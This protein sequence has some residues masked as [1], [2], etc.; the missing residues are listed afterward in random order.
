MKQEDYLNVPS[1]EAG[2]LQKRRGWDIQDVRFFSESEVKKLLYA[3]EELSFLLGRNYPASSVIKLIG[4]RYQL[5]QRQRI[6]LVRSTC[7]P[8]SLVLRQAKCLPISS[9]A[10]GA[11]YIDGFNLII[12][13]EVALSKGIILK[14]QDGCIRDL[15]GLR[16]NYRLIP[17]TDEAIKVL[18]EILETLKAK[19]VHFYLDAPLSNSG[20]L[21][22]KLLENSKD[23]SS[24]VKAEVV[25]NPDQLLSQKE[26]IVTSD[27]IVLDACKSYFNLGAYCIQHSIKDVCIIDLSGE[28][29]RLK[30]NL[31]F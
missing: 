23:W 11:V 31:S 18:G 13:L 9:I 3:Q 5:T 8:Q 21:K 22:V 20:R 28:S 6:A 4:D 14:G 30:D 15:A 19:E 10:E 12:T 27:A 7:S 26:R 17:E 25:N 16:G 1:D 29:G 2:I 24:K